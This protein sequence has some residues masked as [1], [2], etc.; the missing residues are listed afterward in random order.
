MEELVM[1]MKAKMLTQEDAIRVIEEIGRLI[2][3]APQTLLPALQ[4]ANI[5]PDELE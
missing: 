4:Q 1:V 5:S 3:E 2:N